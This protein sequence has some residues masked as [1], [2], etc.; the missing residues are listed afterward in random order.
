MD[1]IVV[2]G[3][4]IGLSLAYEL[5]TRGASVT[6]LEQGQWGG[7][8]SQAAA[9]MLA[10]YKEFKEAGPLFE[11]GRK[12]LLLY[13]EWALQLENETGIDVQLKRGGILTVAA[14][15]G[16]ITELHAKFV[17]QKNAG[18]NLEWLAADVL[19]ER[20]PLL[21]PKM[22]AGIFSTDEGD[23]N[24]QLLLKA[25]HAACLRRGVVMY[26]GNVVTGLV[27]T[28]DRVIGVKTTAGEFHASHTV[29]TAGAWAGIMAEWLGFVNQV[30]PIRGQIAAVSSAGVPLRHVVFGPDGYLVPKRDGRIILGATEDEAGYCRSVTAG[31]V[32]RVLHGVQMII[33]AVADAVFLQAWAGLRPASPDGLP[34]LGPVPDWE[35]ISMAAGHFRNGILLAP[36]TAKLMADWLVEGKGQPLI[37]FY[38]GRLRTLRI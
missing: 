21:S 38:P 5:A 20:E 32:N 16:E 6:L 7:E 11:L 31:G 36:V 25:L 34:L 23:V 2:G 26:E 12:S 35:G 9:G 33:P 29:L 27:T 28:G 19:H 14:S 4:I 8:A 3:G 13:P 24:N 18:C 10:P 22:Q 15:E 1:V 37:P 17:W 30:R